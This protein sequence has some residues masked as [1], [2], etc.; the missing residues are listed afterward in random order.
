MTDIKQ[1]IPCDKMNPPSTVRTSRAKDA[2]VFATTK[3][4][5]STAMN[6]KSPEAI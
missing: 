3:F 1:N 4:L 6:L 5:P 2:I